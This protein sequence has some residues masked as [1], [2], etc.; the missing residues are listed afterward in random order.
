M[1]SFSDFLRNQ[2]GAVAVDWVVLTGSVVGLGLATMAVVSGGVENLATDTAQSLADQSGSGVFNWG[3][4]LQTIASFDFSGGSAEGWFGGQ[5]MDMGGEIGELLVLGRNESTGFQVEIPDGTQEAVM[6]FNLVSGDSLDGEQ[7]TM[8]INGTTVA[9]ATANWRNTTTF[10]IPQLD[11]T[12]VEATVVVERAN[13]GGSGWS[14]EISTVQ[15]TVDQP[16]GNLDFQVHSSTNQNINDEYWGIDNF[17][18]EA[19]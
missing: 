7:A 8:S 1:T 10:E 3:G 17:E 6:S 15:V 4:S 18:A 11:G 2:S 19:R 14:D 12:N 9:I 5:V 13:L 16:T